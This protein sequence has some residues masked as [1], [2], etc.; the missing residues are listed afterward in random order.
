MSTISE[1]DI[2]EGLNSV[3]QRSLQRDEIRRA[4]ADL[5]D[6]LARDRDLRIA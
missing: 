1:R 5:R 4:I 6:R 3:A 2:L